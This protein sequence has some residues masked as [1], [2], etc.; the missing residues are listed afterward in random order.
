MVIF[1]ISR[2]EISEDLIKGFRLFH[3]K[4]KHNLTETAFNDILS[5]MDLSGVTLYRLQKVLGQLVPLEPILIDCCIDSC[6][7]FTKEYETLEYCP[8]CEKT[9]YK[10]GTRTARKQAARS[11]HFECS[12]ETG[13]MQRHS[14]TAKII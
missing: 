10:A 1:F 8:I 9:R 11:L 2:L 6:I 13:K 5:E 4:E 7:A 3:I 12:I 14:D